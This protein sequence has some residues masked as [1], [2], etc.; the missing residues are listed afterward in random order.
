MPDESGSRAAST[1]ERFAEQFVAGMLADHGWNIYFPRWDDGFDFIAV[2]VIGASAVVR[3]VQVKGKYPAKLR[4]PQA[5]YGYLGTLSQTHEDMVLAIPY[6]TLGA[7]DHA[8]PLVAFIPI[9]VLP[10]RGKERFHCTPASLRD[11][12]PRERPDHAKFFGASGMAL[13][14]REDWGRLAVDVVK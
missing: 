12:I 9:S 5:G 2:K 1:R 6:F 11:G 4:E 10:G 7:K 3:P 14:E 13:M 8:P